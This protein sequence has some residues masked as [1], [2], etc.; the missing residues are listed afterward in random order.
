M[1]I[2]SSCFC[3]CAAHVDTDQVEFRD[4]PADFKA[5]VRKLVEKS[6][7][8]LPPAFEMP[9]PRQKTPP[10]EEDAYNPWGDGSDSDQYFDEDDY[11]SDGEEDEMGEDEEDEDD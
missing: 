4:R 2:E 8:E 3:V 10:E 11:G 6:K 5:R 7:A 1:N 9:Q